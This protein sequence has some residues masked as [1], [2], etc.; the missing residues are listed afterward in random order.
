[1]VSYLKDTKKYWQARE[2][3]RIALDS[4]RAKASPMTKARVAEHLASDIRF[5][6]TGRVVS[7]KH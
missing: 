5:L 7:T 1:M 3:A 2:Q 4:K 6:K